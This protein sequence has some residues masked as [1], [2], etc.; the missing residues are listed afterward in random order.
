MKQNNI[1]AIIKISFITILILVGLTWLTATPPK[2]YK[3]K[4]ATLDNLPKT[5]QLIGF[6]DTKFNTSSIIKKNTTIFVGNYESI[7]I[8]NDVQKALNLSPKDYVVVVNMADEPWFMQKWHSNK[9]TKKAKG[10]QTTAWIQD[11][12]GGLRNFLKVPSVNPLQYFIYKV[13]QDGVFRLVYTG[14]V[15]K[16][17]LQGKM[18]KDEIDKE[19]QTLKRYI[20]NNSTAN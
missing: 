19:L 12:D 14:S 6:D 4:I 5:V 10:L 17:A 1:I 7:A 18:R 11:K 9:K 16:G 3:D 15:K 8:A 2:I 20:N 13:N